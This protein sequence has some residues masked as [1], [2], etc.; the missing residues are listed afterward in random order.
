MIDAMATCWRLGDAPCN[1]LWDDQEL[2]LISL[3][4]RLIGYIIEFTTVA[5][6]ELSRR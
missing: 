2:W 1:I 5:C 4:V 6:S 3:V